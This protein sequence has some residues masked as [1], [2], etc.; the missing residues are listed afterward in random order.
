[1]TVSCAARNTGY[2]YPFFCRKLYC[3][4]VVR[5]LGEGSGGGRKSSLA[6]AGT[7]SGTR[8]C[9]SGPQGGSRGSWSCL[10]MSLSKRRS[11]SPAW[12][13][14]G[15]RGGSGGRLASRRVKGSLPH[16]GSSRAGYVQAD[17]GTQTH[18]A[19]F[20]LRPEPGSVCGF[21]ALTPPALGR[22]LPSRWCSPFKGSLEPSCFSLPSSQKGPTPSRAQASWSK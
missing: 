7:G 14:A 1:M 10:R 9:Q 13:P 4:H 18:R 19:P 5:G 22:L 16:P 6:S 20:R 12:G 21:Q 8:G 3:S 2:R 17:P 11:P 15:L